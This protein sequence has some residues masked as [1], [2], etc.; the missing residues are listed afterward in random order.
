MLVKTIQHVTQP[1]ANSCVP[2]CISMVTGVSLDEILKLTSSENSFNYGWT[3]DQEM[4]ILVKLGVYP[5]RSTHVNY[6]SIYLVTVPSINIARHNHRIVLDLRDE[7]ERIV[8]DPNEN[9]EGKLFYD[10][11]I[12]KSGDFGY[13]NITRLIDVSQI[14]FK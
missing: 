10:D 14:N 1:T 9:R 4:A 3:P 12:F 11:S 7:S 6:D 5:E 2:T 8:Y 13:S